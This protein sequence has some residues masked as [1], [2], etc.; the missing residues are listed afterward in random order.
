M[1]VT[2]KVELLGK[3][4]YSDIPNE[5]TLKSIPTASELDYVGAEDFDEVML[6]K[7]LPDVIVEDIDPK[8]L[9]E[10]DYYWVLRAMRLMNYG[11][12]IKVGAVF[13]SKCNE[14]SY[15]DYMGNLETVDVKP[16]PPNFKNELKI[17]R[18]EFIEFK[19]DIELKLLTIQEV[20]NTY[21]DKAFQDSEGNTNTELASM[22][23]MITKIG[24]T[25]V[26]PIDARAKI[27]K[28]MSPADYIILKTRVEEL[29]DYGLRGGGSITCPKCGNTD[30]A[31]LA[32]INER[33]FRPDVDC[34][35]RWATDRNGRKDEDVS[36]A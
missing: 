24:T 36:G 23:Y 31:F 27:K 26:S 33:F 32:F 29:K 3:D 13:C 35:R 34:L 16:L 4:V 28:D 12:Y 10:L 25:P 2:E 11:P 7:I 20:Q 22:C 30:A 5:L 18:D 8:K 14:T 21:K 6:T 1:A 19:S 15:G 17:S 9:L